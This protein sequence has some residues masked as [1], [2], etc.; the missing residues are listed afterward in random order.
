MTDTGRFQYSNTSP[1]TL[2]LA[3][4]LLG[5]GVPAPDLASEIWGS[6]PFAYLRLLGVVLGR[7]RLVAGAG[8]VYSWV[9]LDDLEVTGTSL[10]EAEGLIDA[11]RSTRDADIAVIFKQQDDGKFRVSL[12][13]KGPR[14][15]GAIARAR[16]GGGHELAAGFTAEDVE[17]TVEGIR[18]DLTR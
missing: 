18:R 2:T 9:G 13:S 8:L 7:A 15:V 14:S 11:L 1:E 12:R 16:G 5:L 4:E 3:A 10:D 17:E 6:L